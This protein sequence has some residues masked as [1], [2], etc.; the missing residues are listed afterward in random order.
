LPFFAA[1]TTRLPRYDDTAIGYA[2]IISS[3]AIF[4]TAI[5]I[6]N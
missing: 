4:H 5:F 2:L 6:V 3:I 1:S